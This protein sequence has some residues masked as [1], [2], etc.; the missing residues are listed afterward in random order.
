MARKKKQAKPTTQSTDKDGTVEVQESA[1]KTSATEISVD[2]AEEST[3][4]ATKSSTEEKAEEKIAGV[5][6]Q[7]R[8]LDPVYVPL[9]DASFRLGPKE[10]VVVS[11]DDVTE[12]TRRMDRR[13]FIRNL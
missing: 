6:I 11:A 13:I 4:L 10:S 9:R 5:R 3:T 2:V 1:L 12:D 7:N 8:T